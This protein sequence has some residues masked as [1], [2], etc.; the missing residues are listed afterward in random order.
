ML[1]VTTMVSAGLSLS[2]GVVSV[3]EARV[4]EVGL[5]GIELLAADPVTMATVEV[6][7]AG[8]HGVSF[9]N[10]GA[11]A[12]SIPLKIGGLAYLC[13]VD[14]ASPGLR[15]LSNQLSAPQWRLDRSTL[16]GS[17]V[18]FRME[19]N[20]ASQPVE[21]TNSILGAAGGTGVLVNAPLSS[22][23]SVHHCGLIQAGPFA[24]ATLRTPPTIP[25]SSPPLTS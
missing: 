18:G 24:L 23:I 22:P 7:G 8:K 12:P 5:N 4:R 13:L 25:A 6:I 20:F 2:G 3:T 17:P 16:L 15:V 21:I 19:A 9:G 14:N 11:A 1:T 10:E